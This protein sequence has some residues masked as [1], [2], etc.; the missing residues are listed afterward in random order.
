M[1]VTHP[2]ATSTSILQSRTLAKRVCRGI[3]GLVAD[4]FEL[5]AAAVTSPTRG[6]PRAAY[7][8][9]VA[10]YLAHVGFALGFETIGHAFGRDRTTV[11]HACR[12]VEDSR[13]DAGLDCR[14]ATLEIMCAASGERLYGAPDVSI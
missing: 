4:E 6:A 13:D 5:D 14:L 1:L 12:V 7:A 10:M 9:Q 11:A 2:P 8:R 3:V